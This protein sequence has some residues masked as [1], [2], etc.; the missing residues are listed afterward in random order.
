MLCG[1]FLNVAAG[2]LVAGHSLFLIGVVVAGIFFIGYSWAWRLAGVLIYPA[3][4]LGVIITALT[5]LL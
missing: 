4:M 2:F 1:V 3:T 5:G